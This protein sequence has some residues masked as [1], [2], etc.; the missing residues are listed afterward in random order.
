MWTG[1]LVAGALAAWM[2]VAP[3]GA[4]PS[5]PSD[6]E[7]AAAREEER[8][9]EASVTEVETMLDQLREASEAAAENAGLAAEAYNQAA[10]TR[11]MAE[12]EAETAVGEAEVAGQAL[13][14]ARGVLARVAISAEDAGDGFAV[15]EPFLRADGLDEALERAEL[16]QLAGTTSSRATESYAVAEQSARA[17]AVRADEAVALHAERVDEAERAAVRAERAATA[18]AAQ[19]V[20]AEE[21][22]Q[23][24]LAVLA[25]KRGTTAALEAQA[26]QARI[27]EANERARQRA[28]E[29]QAAQASAAP[30]EPAATPATTGTP[31]DTSASTPGSDATPS[32]TP[33][34]EPSEPSGAEEPSEAPADSAPPSTPAPEGEPAQSAT[35]APPS[36]GV[37]DP[38]AGEAA[39]AWARAQIGKPYQ[40][41]GSGPDA[42][43][44]SGL[45]SAA[46]RDGGGR[47]IPRTAAGQ[48]AAATKVGFDA[49][50]P[51][52]LI[53]WGSS[54]GGIY[55]V[56]IYSGGGMMVEA[57]RAG[58]SVTE[59]PVRWSGV[60]G[61]AG[62]F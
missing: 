11:D 45:T 4:D 33:A 58:E 49:M 56:A 60:F 10:V 14:A 29:A 18:A 15:F 31:S 54:A 47:S 50:R 1:V 43:D 41:G 37:S 40:W 35:P 16:I 42:F 27:A 21:T 59:V 28:E 2:A 38:S 24:L 52:D 12:A 22:H 48:Y 53:F 39:V 23:T 57:P 44:C 13:E 9:A 19:Q 7:L 5:P 46:W 3:A 34:G 20:E 8:L 32:D 55:H 17:A 6:G 62:R 36:T 61:Y 25:T 51:G 30:P 26:E